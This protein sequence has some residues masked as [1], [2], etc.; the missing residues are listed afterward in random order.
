MRSSSGITD[1]LPET[2]DE[3]ERAIV[4]LAADAYAAFLLP[5]DVDPFPMPMRD[6]VSRQTLS[7]VLSHPQAKRFQTAALAD[8]SLGAVFAEHNETSGHIANI[9]RNTGSGGGLQLV[10]LPEMILHN[11]WRKNVDV[12]PSLPDFCS[13]HL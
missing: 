7:V 10:M 13:R 12:T 9:Y 3:L 5:S 11:A 8:S 4:L 1:S 6:D 2:N